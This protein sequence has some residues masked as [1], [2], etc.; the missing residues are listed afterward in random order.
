MRTLLGITLAAILAAGLSACDKSVDP[1]VKSFTYP[2][3]VGNTWIY[4]G[5]FIKDYR[6]KKPNDTLKYAVTA[7]ID[8]V[9]T[10]LPGIYSYGYTET[11]TDSGA[12][13][14]TD[15]ALYADLPDGM[16]R[17]RTLQSPD[18]LGQSRHSL[19]KTIQGGRCITLGGHQFT[20][21]PSLVAALT[22]TSG[23]I[24]TDQSE[25][26]DTLSLILPYPQ[27]LGQQWT[28]WR[29]GSLY[30]WD[31]IRT[32]IGHETIKVATG[33]L[34]CHVIRLTY[35]PPMED[36]EIFE[37]FA[38]EGLVRRTTSLKNLVDTDYQYPY[39][40]GDTL[41][42]VTSLELKSFEIQ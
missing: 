8:R 6:G 40:N 23:I 17:L 12:R 20:D 33:W 38:A 42:V 26:A 10:I 7:F 36:V 30:P 5:Q 3:A 21:V 13:N 19:P 11:S 22:G 35:D 27:S 39:G 24:A 2:M 14:P 16:Y 37:Y 4:E 31:G 28:S 1:K 25:F 15:A 18:R 34:D 41:D 32:I 29:R 9:D